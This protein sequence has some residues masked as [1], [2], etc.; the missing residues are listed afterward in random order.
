MI[1]FKSVEEEE[2]QA[3]DMYDPLLLLTSKILHERW[4][5]IGLGISAKTSYL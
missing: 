2:L 1:L 3:F 5:G 4:V